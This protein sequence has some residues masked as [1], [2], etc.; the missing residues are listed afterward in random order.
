MF[1]EVRQSLGFD[2]AG[3]QEGGQQGG[4]DLSSARVEPQP[5]H[6]RRRRSRS[7]RRVA[8]DRGAGLRMDRA[9]VERRLLAQWR[10]MEPQDRPLPSEGAHARV[11]GQGTWGQA[12]LS[13]PRLI[14]DM[15]QSED[16]LRYGCVSSVHLSLFLRWAEA[17][18]R[19]DAEFR[20][21]CVDVGRAI[22]LRIFELARD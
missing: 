18:L 10:G 17:K 1:E 2:E 11:F 19:R 5:V 8:F 12:F 21:V 9:V 6:E 13:R 14:R 3:G 20:R 7:P 22:G 16:W 15:L 4:E